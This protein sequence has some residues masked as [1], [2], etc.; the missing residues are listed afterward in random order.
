M[1]RPTRTANVFIISMHY[2]V[3]T[4]LCR[5]LLCAPTYT[6]TLC[7]VIL[8]SFMYKS[9]RARAD[10]DEFSE[11]PSIIL[12]H[13]I[14]HARTRREREFISYFRRSRR[15]RGPHNL[16]E[17]KN[18]HCISVFDYT[19]QRF[20]APDAKERPGPP[21]TKLFFF[22]F[23]YVTPKSTIKLISLFTICIICPFSEGKS[24]FHLRAC[25]R[26]NV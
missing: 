7:R 14:H 6:H 22:L 18:L 8:F 17:E 2:I 11:S 1:R 19:T 10:V 9:I 3:S 16:A 25:A 5:T 26:V 24:I 4:S 12:D 15:P 21:I 13:K 20:W 23:S